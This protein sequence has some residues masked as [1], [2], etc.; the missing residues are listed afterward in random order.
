MAIDWSFAGI[1]AFGEELAALV[2]PT[3]GLGHA[4]IDWLAPLDRTTFGPYLEGLREGGWQGNPRLVRYIYCAALYLRYVIGVFGEFAGIFDDAF[5][6]IYEQDFG[7]SAEEI[8]DFLG[9]LNK[10]STLMGD[11]ALSLYNEFKG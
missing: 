11:E 9:S 3:V 8:M 6:P 2:W 10:F 5:R 4:P 7:M 1:A